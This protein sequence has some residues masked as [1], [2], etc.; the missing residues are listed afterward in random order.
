MLLCNKELLNF[1]CCCHFNYE[2]ITV[3]PKGEGTLWG[4]EEALSRC[5]KSRPSPGRAH[6]VDMGTVM[7]RTECL[8]SRDV[9]AFPV[10]A[11]LGIDKAFF[12][13]KWECG[14]CVQ[15]LATAASFFFPAVHSRRLLPSRDLLLRQLTPPPVFTWVCKSAES[16]FVE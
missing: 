7:S 11:R 3:L 10:W 16:Q 14:Q 1:C 6:T 5:V 4:A 9:K 2:W 8:R 15:T 13:C 12:C